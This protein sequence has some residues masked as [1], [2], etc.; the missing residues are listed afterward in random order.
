MGTEISEEDLDNITDLAQQVIDLQAYRADLGEYISK[1]MQAIAPNLTILLGDLIGARL[2]AQVGSLLGLAKI[3]ASSLQ[4]LGAE[5]ALFRAL[6]TKE[7]TP[8]YGIIYQA[9]L[10]GQ[11]SPKNKGKVSR[12]LAAKAALSSR[13]D[14]LSEKDDTAMIG[15]LLKEIILE[16]IQELE[17]GQS[18]K[19]LGKPKSLARQERYDPKKRDST[20]NTAIPTYDTKTDVVLETSEGVQNVEGKKDKKEKK[21]KKEKK[22]KKDKKDKKEKK[23]DKKRKEEPEDE[24]MEDAKEEKKDKKKNIEKVEKVKKKDKKKKDEKETVD[25]GDS[26][27]KKD[28]KSSKKRKLDDTENVEEKKKKKKKKE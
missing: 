9:S 7:D 21:E 24:E 18:S 17:K 3:P 6:K 25:D 16:R 27:K 22:D 19:K 12:S 2:I 1:R 11:T 13:V 20:I 26:K 28:K 15:P 8:K 23:K 10:I 14:A 5:K 4:L